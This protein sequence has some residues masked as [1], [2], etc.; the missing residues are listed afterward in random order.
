MNKK[1]IAQWFDKRSH[2]FD[3]LYTRKRHPLLVSMDRIFRKNI[4][5]RFYRVGLVLSPL[6]DRRI[7]DVGCG[8]GQ[9]A[10]SFALSGAR[11]VVGVDLSPAMLEMAQNLAEDKGVSERCKFVE[12]EFMR[13]TIEG[14]FNHSI[15]IG[16]FDYNADTTEV[17]KKM[18]SL[19][20][21]KVVATFPMFWAPRVPL[22]KLWLTF[23]RCPVY[24]YTRSDV[25]K[26]F[27]IAGIRE[28]TI[29]QFYGLYF[30][31]GETG[32]RERT[33]G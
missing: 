19:T 13:T 26:I 22:R 8:S 3:S 30:A 21:G 15:A 12:G 33:D 14:P 11:E 32:S 6:K 16:F 10:V 18:A 25:E 23:K 1:R 5:E 29:D 17:L 7:L 27:K 2:G 31:V 9:Y 28:V 20:E 4:P 24:F